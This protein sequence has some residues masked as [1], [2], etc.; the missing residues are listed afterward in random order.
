V[1]PSCA[2]LHAAKH[3]RGGQSCV[4][5]QPPESSPQPHLAP[6][7]RCSLSPKCQPRV[8][9]LCNLETPLPT[10]MHDTNRLFAPIGGL[11]MR[12]FAPVR[13]AAFGPLRI[14]TTRNAP[15]KFAGPALHNAHRLSPPRS[16]AMRVFANPSHHEAPL[17]DRSRRP[18]R[19]QTGRAKPAFCLRSAPRRSTR[20]DTCPHGS[21]ARPRAPRS[22]PTPPAPP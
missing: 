3:R 19:R 15:A 7:P 17:R 6:N 5:R 9:A 11:T 8:G 4:G 20:R 13:S 14:A 2:L 16:S 21:H 22:T 12:R 10:P 18:Q 1:P